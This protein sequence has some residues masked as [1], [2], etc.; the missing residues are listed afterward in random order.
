MVDGLRIGNADRLQTLLGH[1]TRLLMRVGALLKAELAISETLLAQGQ[2]IPGLQELLRDRSLGQAQGEDLEALITAHCG[3]NSEVVTARASDGWRVLAHIDEVDNPLVAATATAQPATQ[4]GHG[5]HADL[6]LLAD[7][8]PEAMSRALRSLLAASS[9][10]LRAAAVEQLR[11]LRPGLP[12]L[13]ALIPLFLGDGAPLVRDAARR[14]LID[15]GVRP[16][17]SR[18]MDHLQ[19][20]DERSLPAL[21]EELAL[22]KAED[23][24]LAITALRSGLRQAASGNTV[25]ALAEP[26]TSALVQS[27]QLEPFLADLIEQGS[28]LNLLGLVRQLQEIDGAIVKGYLQKLLGHS[29]EGDA[30]LIAFLVHPGVILADEL[31]QRGLD[32]LLSPAADPSDRMGLASALL[33][34]AN[35]EAIRAALVTQSSDLAKVRDSAAIWLIGEWAREG[36]FT[37]QQAETLLTPLLSLIEQ[38][39]G[40]Q[41]STLL[42]Q[43]LPASLPLS[44]ELAGLAIPELGEV[45]A[46][47]RSPRNLE[48]I[49]RIMLRLAP[50]NPELCWRLIEEHPH[51]EPRRLGLTCLPLALAGAEAQI[52]ADTIARCLR[53]CQRLPSGGRQVKD[54]RQEQ[55]LALCIAGEL[56]HQEQVPVNEEFRELA[57]AIDQTASALGPHGWQALGIIAA[58]RH[59]HPSRR[60][61]LVTGFLQT[62]LREVSD[63][64]THE[65]TISTRQGEQQTV[66]F[67]PSLSAHTHFVPDLL[68]ALNIAARSPYLPAPLLRQVVEGLSSHFAAIAR[69]EVMWAPG[70]I[71]QLAQLLSGLASESSF[72]NHLR[73]LIVRAL[74][75]RLS[76]PEMVRALARVLAADPNGELA[77]QAA[78]SLEAVISHQADGRYLDDERVE[79]AHALVEFLAIADLGDDDALLRRRLAATLSGLKRQCRETCRIRLRELLAL[80]INQELG[81]RLA[82]AH[83][84]TLPVPEIR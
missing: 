48:L 76:Q 53:W 78:Q 42:E 74:Q 33:R 64:G 75:T 16:A 52:I 77:A 29:R 22:L 58:G 63:Q 80:P 71:N 28:S 41:V 38:G 66:V 26:L 30:R 2:E 7:Q 10:E 37:V 43:G 81:Q 19:E 83:S 57:S 65:Q 17:V 61:S 35:G 47:T 82:W 15:S 68:R 67:D 31:L 51:A 56:L 12:L 79:L 11:Y 1:D 25:I 72:P 73:R 5:Q 20:P 60:S 69:W 14:L 36:A 23:A 59:C 27:A 39:S 45:A 40:P 50:G 8:L 13:Q 9:D 6:V 3:D 70:N 49:E 32:L 55:A 84:S 46:R 4:S 62:C 21:R 24:E 18:L 34:A 54:R 44:P